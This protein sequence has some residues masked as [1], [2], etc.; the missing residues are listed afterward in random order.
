MNSVKCP[1]CGRSMNGS[2][3]KRWPQFPFCS[4]RCKTIDFGRWLGET[5]R[6]PAEEPEE[7]AIEERD[8]P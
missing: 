1:I 7:P 4:Q 3:F 2:D 5:Y 8:V 6:V